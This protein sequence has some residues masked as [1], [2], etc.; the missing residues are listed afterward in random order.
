MK[1]NVQNIQGEKSI[2]HGIRFRWHTLKLYKE[3]YKNIQADPNDVQNY[4]DELNIKLQ[5]KS[6]N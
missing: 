6:D 1:Y 5:E 4:Y 2:S 3:A